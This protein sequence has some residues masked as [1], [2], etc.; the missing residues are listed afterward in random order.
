MSKFTDLGKSKFI[1]M[2][3]KYA[4]GKA[5][6]NVE[7]ITFSTTTEYINILNDLSMKDRLSKSEIIRM[8]LLNFSRLE[9]PDREKL[10]EE[11]YSKRSK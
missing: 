6:D 11:V 1:N 3:S 10:Y 7:K 2:A 8:S 5:N 4:E 9:K